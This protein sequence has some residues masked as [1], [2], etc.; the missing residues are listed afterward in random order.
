M[1]RPSV[2][3]PHLTDGGQSNERI[4]RRGC[5]GHHM[6]FNWNHYHLLPNSP[7]VRRLPVPRAFTNDQRTT[8]VAAG[9]RTGFGPHHRT[10]RRCRHRVR[11]KDG[12]EDYLIR[13]VPLNS[14]AT[15]K[16]GNR[17]TRCRGLLRIPELPPPCWDA[18]AAPEAACRGS[19]RIELRPIRSSQFQ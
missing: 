5:D 11:A 13:E 14:G 7:A 12:V 18:L 2:K 19:I 9:P 4:Y 8:C 17:P 16:Q 3:E 1:S 10:G 6:H 15:T